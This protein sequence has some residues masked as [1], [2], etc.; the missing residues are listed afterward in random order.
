MQATCPCA[1]VVSASQEQLDVFLVDGQSESAMQV[2]SVE[3]GY[4]G[5]VPFVLLLCVGN[6][7]Y[8]TQS[9]GGG[10]GISSGTHV[11]TTRA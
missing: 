11:M 2:F 1:S 5:D 7:P 3:V 6:N 9:I 8:I 10:G 4:R